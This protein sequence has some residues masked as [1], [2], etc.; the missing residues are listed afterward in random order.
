MNFD[1]LVEVAVHMCM[2]NVLC[3]TLAPVYG[4]HSLCIDSPSHGVIC[5]WRPEQLCMKQSVPVTI[6]ASQLPHTIQYCSTQFQFWHAG[7]LHAAISG[8]LYVHTP[9]PV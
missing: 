9:L 2:M 7:C 3:R 4:P 8:Q 1:K 5:W 6:H